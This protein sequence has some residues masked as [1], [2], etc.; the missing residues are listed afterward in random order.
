MLTVLAPLSVVDAPRLESSTITIHPPAYTRWQPAAP[1][2]TVRALAG[3]RV[4]VNGLLIGNDGVE[5]INVTVV[6]RVAPSCP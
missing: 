6:N 4:V 5:G 2:P 1:S 3:S